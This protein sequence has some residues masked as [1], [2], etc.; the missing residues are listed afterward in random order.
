MTSIDD[1]IWNA[2][3]EKNE[4]LSTYE[5]AKRCKISWSTADRHCFKL[6]SKRKIKCK[7]EK[8]EVGEGKKTLWWC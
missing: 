3:A 6:Y 5:I 7:E 1:I 4:K 2:L 8:A